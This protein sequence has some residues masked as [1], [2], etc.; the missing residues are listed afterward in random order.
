MLT[1][2]S[3]HVNLETLTAQMNY[4]ESSYPRS[5]AALS[6]L[7]AYPHFAGHFATLGS[8]PGEQ[9]DALDCS[10]SR[11]Y[12]HSGHLNF[13]VDKILTSTPHRPR[14]RSLS[15]SENDSPGR[16]DD[17][18]I[19]DLK[20]DGKECQTVK[21]RRTRTNFTGW[22]LEELEKAFQDSHYPDVFMREALA[23]KLDLVESRVQVWFQNRRAKW[24][25]KEN[26]KKGPG[27]PPHNA[28][29]QT[30]SG[31]PM[32]AS[33]VQKREQERNE[34]RKRK[35]EERLRRLEEKRKMLGQ[36]KL[37]LSM[38]SSESSDISLSSC[39]VQS[40][41]C[42]VFPNPR[43]DNSAEEHDN[44]S[45]KSLVVKPKCPFS[46]D[47]ILETPK[48]P[49]GRRP[50]SKYPRVQA[51]KSLGPLG[52]G[53]MPL[54]PI[55]QP[56]GFVVE[57]MPEGEDEDEDFLSVGE[58]DIPSKESL[59]NDL[60]KNGSENQDKKQSR[61][62]ST[63]SC[64]EHSTDQTREQFREQ[65]REQCSDQCVED[66]SSKDIDVITPDSDIS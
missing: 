44:N 40:N 21:R 64:I 1:N 18:K 14:S 10:V 28:H 23:L 41:P 39:D 57:Q 54:Y 16:F 25:K 4:I 30:C 34:K 24:R 60:D 65:S 12:F 38:L 66:E 45:D 51:C 50:N 22:Q 27:R 11:G 17:S 47:S 53:M 48:V 63:E 55:T 2:I 7:A 46:I 37:K 9:I 15:P 61:E 58:C 29:P 62:Q 6:T 49:R 33:E 52:I 59:R 56:I 3:H 43:G 8:P 32:E 19:R 13:S 26:T 5:Y 42:S 20:D 31:E 36:G 35:Q